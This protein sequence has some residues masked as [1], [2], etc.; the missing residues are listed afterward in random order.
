[1]P[2]SDVVPYLR[3]AKPSAVPQWKPKILQS[4]MSLRHTELHNISFNLSTILKLSIPCIFF[5][6][7]ISLIYQ[8]LIIIHVL[9]K[10]LKIKIY[11]TIILPLV[12]YGCETWSLTLRGGREAEGV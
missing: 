8:V 10:N 12:L 4:C 1:V 11:R 2:P 9:S 5:T 3:R 6:V 7:I